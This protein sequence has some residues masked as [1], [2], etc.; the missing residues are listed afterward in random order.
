VTR[1]LLLP[2]GFETVDLLEPSQNL[3]AEARRS[4][5]SRV[6][7]FLDLPLQL[8]P[9][10]NHEQQQ[11]Q[12][13][14]VVWTQWVL[15]YLTDEDLVEFF[16]AAAKALR[17]GGVVVVKENVAHAEA[18]VDEEDCSVT[19]TAEEYKK[20]AALADMEILLEMKQPIWPSDL[21][22]VLMLALAPKTLL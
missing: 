21:F 20:L 2:F 8:W 18:V 22:P 13:Y 3:L 14:D 10:N 7:L 16:R 9:S 19:R 5:G 1:D 12:E 11:R 17:P 15:L 6:R 4:L